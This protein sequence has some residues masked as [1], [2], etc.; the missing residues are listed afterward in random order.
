[1][2]VRDNE[3]RTEHSVKQLTVCKNLDTNLLALSSFDIRRHSV[4]QRHISFDK[5]LQRFRYRFVFKA[6][7]KKR[8]TKSSDAISK[9]RRRQTAKSSHEA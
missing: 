3:S 9:L 1:M 2:N 5:L 7:K 6:S 4:D 8:L